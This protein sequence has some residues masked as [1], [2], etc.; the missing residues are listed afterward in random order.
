MSVWHRFLIV[1]KAI[2]CAFNKEK[3]LVGAFSRHC[4]TLWRFVEIST[5][6]QSNENLRSC[7][8]TFLEV[9]GERINSLQLQTDAIMIGCDTTGNLP[10]I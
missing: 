5:N 1:V 8:E 6:I 4:E 2:V 3:A 10:W 9:S 7:S